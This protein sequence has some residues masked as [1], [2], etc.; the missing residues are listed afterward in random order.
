MPLYFDYD[1]EAEDPAGGRDAPPRQ[2]PED[3]A[4]RG[5]QPRDC[6]FVATH[7]ARFAGE[8]LGGAV[9]SGP[10]IEAATYAALHYNSQEED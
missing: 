4:A 6:R 1:R 10:S 3:P 5:V 8:E 2:C 9:E 7:A